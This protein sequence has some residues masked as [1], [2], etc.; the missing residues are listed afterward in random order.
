MLARRRCTDDRTVYPAG[1]YPPVRIVAAS[2]CPLCNRGRHSQ[3][4]HGLVLLQIS[5]WHA[6]GFLERRMWYKLMPRDAGRN[7]C[8]LGVWHGTG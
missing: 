6:C 4:C 5:P 7:V 2:L 3:L 8:V 1:G